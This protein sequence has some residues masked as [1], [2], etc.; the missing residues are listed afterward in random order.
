MLLTKCS[1]STCYHH[2]LIC[3]Y[4]FPSNA[5]KSEEEENLYEN[6][7]DNARVTFNDFFNFEQPYKGKSMIKVLTT[8]E[9]E[10]KIKILHASLIQGH[11]I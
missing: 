10:C 1:Y 3:Y 7:K 5:D 2:V 9:N 6:T 11:K 8:S 4:L